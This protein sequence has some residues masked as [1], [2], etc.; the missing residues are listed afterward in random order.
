MLS[1]AEKRTGSVVCVFCCVGITAELFV[2]QPS[3]SDAFGTGL[4]HGAHS[5][6]DLTECSC[7]L[8]SDSCGTLS[9]R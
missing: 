2:R 4:Q 3:E 5:R 6:V 9:G 7:V 1:M 8:V